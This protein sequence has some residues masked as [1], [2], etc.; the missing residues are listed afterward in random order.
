MD[1]LSLFSAILPHSCY[2][3]CAVNSR[4]QLVLLRPVRAGEA[5][6]IDYAT[7]YSG[8]EPLLDCRCGYNGC[9]GKILGFS[10]LP[11]IFQDYYLE[12]DAVGKEV[13]MALNLNSANY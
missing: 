2:P 10:Y 8:R 13:L 12:K 6:T 3:N 1:N 4:N 5:L 7:L 9:R 11:V